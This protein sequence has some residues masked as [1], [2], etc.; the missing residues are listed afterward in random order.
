ME[1]LKKDGVEAGLFPAQSIFYTYYGK[2]LKNKLLF[3]AGLSSIYRRID[4]LLREEVEQFRPDVIWIF[5]GMEIMPSFLSWAREK[6]I[7]TVNFNPDN[8]FLFSG[9]GSGNANVTRSI[10]LYD[11]HFSYDRAICERIQREY[12]ITARVLPFGYEL[13]DGLYEECRRQEEIKALCFLGNPDAQR[14][15]FIGELAAAGL[16]VHVY[17]HGWKDAIRHAGV[18]V[19]GPVYG[20]DFWRVLYRYRVQLNLMRPHNPQSH[21]MRSFEIPGVGGIGLFPDTPDHRQ[22]FEDGKEVFIYRDTADAGRLARLI[23]EMSA[24]QAAAVRRNARQRSVSGGYS[25]QER[26]RSVLPYLQLQHA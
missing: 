26:I 11:L 24:D 15:A 14:A 21:N 18:T 4:V 20:D 6:N 13:T 2:S 22:Y 12:K 3:K 17:G 10:G 19:N 23:L 7:M 5:K 1:H 16:P 9:P 8:P 25:Y